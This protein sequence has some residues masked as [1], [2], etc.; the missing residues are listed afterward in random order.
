MSNLK[1][2]II[3]FFKYFF[4][5]ALALVIIIFIMESN[6][7]DTE[8]QSN[9]K[10]TINL[11]DISNCQRS[12]QGKFHV[13]YTQNDFEYRFHFNGNNIKIWR[14]IRDDKYSWAGK[15][16]VYDGEWKFSDINRHAI[17]TFGQYEAAREINLIDIESSDFGLLGLRTLGGLRLTSE[18]IRYG[19][20]APTYYLKKGW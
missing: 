13:K 20:S 17:K 7:N 11:N 15:S 3:E 9:T 12:V 1:N 10:A 4:G 5:T 19:T 14:K 6:K 18:D 16:A 2:N 8:N